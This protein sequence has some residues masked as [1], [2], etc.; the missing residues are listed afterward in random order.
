MPYTPW[1]QSALLTGGGLPERSPRQD[2]PQALASLSQLPL[3]RTSSAASGSAALRMEASSLR[4]WPERWPA[5][6]RWVPFPRINEMGQSGCGRRLN[7]RA[8]VRV[9]VW[10]G[11]RPGVLERCV[12][13][14]GSRLLEILKGP[15]KPNRVD[16]L[17][18]SVQTVKRGFERVSMFSQTRQGLLGSGTADM[19]CP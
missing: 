1:G 18:A 8:G 17:P 4:G 2:P 7:K 13:V 5:V 14:I 9:A 10:L 19:S 11:C 16:S 15:G 3:L 6:D 12:S